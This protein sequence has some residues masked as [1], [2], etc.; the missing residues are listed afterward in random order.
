M[1]DQIE[2]GDYNEPDYSHLYKGGIKL[3]EAKEEKK[4]KPGPPLYKYLE[5]K[6]T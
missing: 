2:E 1:Q 3:I 4:K 5:P 6:R